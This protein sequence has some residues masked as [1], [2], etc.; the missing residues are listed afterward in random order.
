MAAVGD[1]VHRLDRSR[2]QT[3]WCGQ[4]ER[5]IRP[6]TDERVGGRPSIISVNLSVPPSCVFWER[7]V[8]AG[9]PHYRSMTSCS[10]SWP[11]KLTAPLSAA[12]SCLPLA[13]TPYTHNPFIVAYTNTVHDIFFLRTQQVFKTLYSANNF[14]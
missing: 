6:G 5:P 3:T 13:S 9:D 10:L 7:V 1:G 4:D 14:M 8:V 2:Q 11:N 12:Y